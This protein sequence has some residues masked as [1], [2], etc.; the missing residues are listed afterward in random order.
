MLRRCGRARPSQSQSGR[1]P[2]RPGCVGRHGSDPCPA[3]RQLTEHVRVSGRR[4]PSA[5]RSSRGSAI[6]RPGSRCQ[7]VVLSV[8]GTQTARDI[9]GHVQESA[10][11]AQTSGCASRIHISFGAVMIGWSSVPVIAKSSSGSIWAENW[12]VCW[13]VRRSN[14]AI[15]S[16][17]GSSCASR[18]TPARPCW[19]PPRPEYAGD[20]GYL[21]DRLSEHLAAKLP[22]PLRLV[23]RPP[24]MRVV[25]LL[26]RG[27]D[28]NR[29][30]VR[31]DNGCLDIGC[32]DIQAD[33]QR[34]VGR[35]ERIDQLDSSAPVKRS[36]KR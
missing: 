19:R 14:Q 18:V 9:R 11:R 32:A 20:W 2:G 10:S 31:A 24:W 8:V 36:Y 23:A 25:D 26:V 28:G 5:G 27:C 4:S 33:E 12:S 21:R 15:T 34:P 1:Q 29:L 13:T 35:G 30:P 6:E 3:G 22:D 17:V 16:Y 7:G